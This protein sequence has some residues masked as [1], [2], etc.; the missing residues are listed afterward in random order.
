M[1]NYRG[2]L[3]T[4]SSE[5]RLHSTSSAVCLIGVSCVRKQLSSL[6]WQTES[7]FNIKKKDKKTKKPGNALHRRV[8]FK[9]NQVLEPDYSFF[10][11]TFFFSRT[12]LHDVTAVM[13]AFS[14]KERATLLLCQTNHWR[15][16]SIW[17]IFFSPFLSFFFLFFFLIQ[18]VWLLHS[19]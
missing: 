6:P 4:P 8:L 1:L 10:S 19:L 17:H 11:T 16:N 5:W 2:I 15:L 14:D 12:F 3:R 9:S 18:P 13:M 7:P